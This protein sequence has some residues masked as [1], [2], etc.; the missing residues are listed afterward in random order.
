MCTP[1]WYIQ[2][3][4]DNFLPLLPYD[5]A[6]YLEHLYEMNV[7]RNNSLQD[8]LEEILKLFNQNGIDTI[9]LKGAAT[10]CD[11]LYEPGAR[12]MGD[13]DILVPPDKVLLSQELIT[14]LGYVP[15][16]E[17][18][19]DKNKLPIDIR[20]H[21]IVRHIKSGT[22][23]VVEIHYRLSHGQAGRTFNIDEVWSQCV[24]NNFR[25]QKTALLNPTHRV[26]L[27]FVHAMLPDREYLMGNLSILQWT[28]FVYLNTKYEKLINYKNLL[29]IINR[30]KLTRMF[31]LYYYFSVIY[32]KM[33]NFLKTKLKGLYLYL[34]IKRILLISKYKYNNS[35]SKQL[36][37][38]TF[39]VIYYVRLIKW[40]WDNQCYTIDTLTFMDRCVFCGKKLF[41]KKNY[42]HYFFN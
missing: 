41:T 1:L 10:F 18:E 15:V 16:S 9:L 39:R 33:P 12:F 2:L 40:L 42:K 17:P 31:N 37:L 38:F 13:L 22:P 20:K 14:S 5:L 25:S 35:L 3:K 36:I 23:L 19:L 34:D 11:H 29:L 30:K 6:E 26:L 7:E 4:K 24:I 21:H 8:G 32:F 28:E 27:N